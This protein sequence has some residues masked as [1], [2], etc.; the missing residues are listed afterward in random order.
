LGP[1][2]VIVCQ[3]GGKTLAKGGLAWRPEA[4]VVVSQSPSF[5]AQTTIV[6]TMLL[7]NTNVCENTKE[8][9][10]QEANLTDEPKVDPL[11]RNIGRIS[12]PS[13]FFSPTVRCSYK[14]CVYFE[15]R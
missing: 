12:S 14:K 2:W 9:I 7:R 5:K 3:G 10:H 11:L 15:F 4:L 13:R 8:I 6:K 1:N